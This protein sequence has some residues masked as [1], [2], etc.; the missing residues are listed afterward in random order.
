VVLVTIALGSDADKTL[1]REIATTPNHA[2]YAPDTGDLHDI[3]AKIAGVVRC[4]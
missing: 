1:L 3:Y 4:R 2:Y